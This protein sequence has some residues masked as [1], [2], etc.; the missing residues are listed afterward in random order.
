MST[1][2][3]VEL[4]VEYK[5]NPLGIDVMK[6]RLSWQ[7]TSEAHPARQTAFQILTATSRTALEG[8]EGDLWDTGKVTADESIQIVYDGEPLQSR[9]VCWWKVRAWNDNDEAGPWSEPAVWTMGLLEPAD[10]TARWIGFDEPAPP[11]PDEDSAKVIPPAVYFRKKFVCEKEIQRATVYASALGAYELRMNGEKIGDDVLTP[12][13]PDFHKRVYY[14]TYDVTNQMNQSENVVAVL[15]GPGW[16]SGYMGWLIEE[17]G[18]VYGKHSRARV[19]LELQYTDGSRAIV[20]TEDTWRA[21]HGPIIG[22]DIYMGE[23]FDARREMPGW[24]NTGFDDSAWRPAVIDDAYAG[25]IE[26]YP[27]IPV[28]KM[29]EIKPVALHEPEPGVWVYDLGQNM[30]GYARLNVCGDC[31]DKV[32]LRFAEVLNPD[33]TVYVANLRG[34]RATDEYWLGGKN[35]TYEPVFTFHGFRYVEMR[36]FLGEPT[37]DNITGVVLYNDLPETGRFETSNAMVNQLQSNIVW[38]QRGNFLEVPTDCPQRDERLGW[39]GDAQ[40]FIR[41]GTFNMDTAPFYTKWMRDVVDG[42]GE[43][44]AF[45]DVSPRACAMTDGAPAWGDAG[46]IVPWTMYRVYGD[47]R[48]IETYYDAMRRWID[49]VHEGNPSLIRRERLNSN[50]GDW[51]SINADTPKDLLATAYFAYDCKLMAEMAQVAGKDDDVEAYTTLF[52]DIRDAFNKEYVQPDGAIHGDTQTAYVLA[53]KF[54]LLSDELKVKAAEKLVQNIRNL[55]THLS[56]GFV[57]GGYLLPVLTD[58]GYLDVAYQLLLNETFPSWGYTIRHGATTIWERWDGWTHDKGF[59]N[60]G[61]NSFNHYAFGSVG[62]W[63]YATVAGIDFSAPGYKQLVLHPRPGGGLTRAR[64]EYHSIRGTIVSDWQIADDVFGWQATVPANTTAAI[65]VPA[66]YA[67]NISIQGPAGEIEMPE[68]GPVMVG[69]GVYHIRGE[70][71]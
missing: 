31:G 37:L 10:W 63:L 26:A 45:A 18:V 15:L 9:Q 27:G 49:Y 56:T 43:N 65:H 13:W 5:Q 52:N 61:M 14:N 4:H 55:D 3:P 33:G 1:L 38:G 25:A 21:S 71:A 17:P 11:K 70:L 66:K 59:Q 39:M 28:R 6:P 47:T 60:P 40:I 16:Y 34:A 12:G 57:G 20:A 23:Q 8:N 67:R 2:R 7:L 44:G 36:G 41:T 30:V 62:E 46:V 50:Y 68:N 58:A 24:D 64:G 54:G 29:F 69:S 48:I 22:A 35:E 42:Q 32:T 53:L 51:L 19:Q